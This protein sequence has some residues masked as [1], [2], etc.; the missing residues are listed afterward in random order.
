MKS[1]P[2][3]L[4][5][6][7]ITAVLGLLYGGWWTL[8]WK[9]FSVPR[10]YSLSFSPDGKTLAGAGGYA[11]AHG[12]TSFV[13][14]LWL[15]DGHTGEQRAR[16]VS[17]REPLRLV[18]FS[19]DG[20]QLVGWQMNDDAFGWNLVNGRWVTMDNTPSF[21]EGFGVGVIRFLPD[22]EGLICRLL[23]SGCRLGNAQLKLHNQRLQK[24]LQT[25]KRL[26]E[27]EDAL[28]MSDG[29]ELVAVVRAAKPYEGQMAVSIRDAHTG[30][31]LR[32]YPR[33]LEDVRLARFS[34]DG[35][36]LLIVQWIGGGLA[37]CVLW[38][39]AT[40]EVVALQDKQYLS[41]TTCAFSPDGK[42]V[43][44]GGVYGEVQLWDTKT[45]KS[46][47]QWQGN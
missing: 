31:L 37:D 19:E 12:S 11:E 21:E 30:K 28:A 22:Q 27:Q 10:I 18:A 35:K 33:L 29:A 15:W 41:P 7:L 24:T 47:A 43:A 4:K 14:N 16:L 3:W 44:V 20:Q 39:H 45:G 2:R 5:P 6:L 1:R 26:G 8:K 25:H 32:K 17:A 38:N 34:P 23:A 13:G 46:L 9:L 40:N 36:W 42:R